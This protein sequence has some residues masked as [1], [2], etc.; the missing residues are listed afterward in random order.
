MTTQSTAVPS[1][2]GAG[3]AT[4]SCFSTLVTH[5][6]Q[7]YLW[8]DIK[9]L[10]RFALMDV[11]SILNTHLWRSFKNIN[12]ISPQLSGTFTSTTQVSK[13]RVWC[14]CRRVWMRSPPSS[15]IQTH[16]R[17]MGPSPCEVL[18]AAVIRTNKHLFYYW[19]FYF[20]YSYFKLLGNLLHFF[21]SGCYSSII[22]CDTS[23]CNAW[24]HSNA[25]PE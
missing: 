18:N 25:L 1:R 21:I 3:E 16:F 5:L 7:D 20:F 15:W 19:L 17:M 13:T 8:K 9:N 23:H 24:I 4:E 14:T 22:F 2:G 12:N 11:F 6:C 10:L